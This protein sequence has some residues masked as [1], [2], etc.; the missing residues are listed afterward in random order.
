MSG[1]T[2]IRTYVLRTGRMTDAQR[3]A[4]EELGPRYLLPFH[5]GQRLDY[6]SAFGDRRPVVAE[7]GF[8]MGQATWRIALE[9]PETGYLGIEVH[10]PGI[11]KLLIDIAEHDVRNIRI[12]HHDAVE[13]LER[14]IAPASLAGLHIFYPDPWPKKKHHKRRLIREGLAEL[15]A[16]RLAPGAYLYFVTDIEE[17]AQWSLELLSRTPGLRNRHEGYAPKQAWRPETKFEARAKGDGR[18][19]WEL[20]FERS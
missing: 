6:T 5:P 3:R 11:G 2:S 19:V 20:L 8:G 12:I 7:I 16:S 14:M 15:L 10:T 13:V 1:D 18:A 17:Y 9:N 4:L